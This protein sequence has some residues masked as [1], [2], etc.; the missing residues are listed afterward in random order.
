MP[1]YQA[2]RNLLTTYGESVPLS[3]DRKS[4]GDVKRMFR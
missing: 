4:L 1:S 3:S 2:T